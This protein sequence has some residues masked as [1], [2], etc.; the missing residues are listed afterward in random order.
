MHA[1]HMRQLCRPANQ[2]AGAKGTF[3]FIH[4]L[5]IIPRI[6]RYL[7]AALLMALTQLAAQENTRLGFAGTEPE[8]VSSPG[9]TS[10]VAQLTWK[11]VL[12]IKDGRFFLDGEPFSEISFNKFDLF[13]Q[14]YDQLI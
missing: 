9:T 8:K 12:S 10:Q 13:W 2:R 5:S 3:L 1:A 4:L 11:D 14:L 7:L 6:M